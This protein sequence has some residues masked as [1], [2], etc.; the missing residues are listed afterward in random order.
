M[1]RAYEYTSNYCLPTYSVLVYLRAY[2]RSTSTCSLTLYGGAS[3]QQL[4][5]AERIS[6]SDSVANRI[7]QYLLL[8]DTIERPLAEYGQN[9]PI[10]IL[11][12]SYMYESILCVIT[13]RWVPSTDV[14]IRN[15]L[16]RKGE[17]REEK[18]RV[19]FVATRT[20]AAVRI[21]PPLHHLYLPCPSR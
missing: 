13:S 7:Y 11:D 4:S 20:D 21:P 19:R 1:I 5:D 14:A 17:M 15:L 6:V 12:S 8:A 3:V 10:G 2:M 16:K 18:A 9:E